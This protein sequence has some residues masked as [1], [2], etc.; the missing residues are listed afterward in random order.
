[1][2]LLDDDTLR[3]LAIGAGFLG[4]GGG[5]DTAY[6]LLAARQAVA[7]HGA[8]RLL[9][10][11]ELPDDGLLLPTG[12]MGAPTV[13]IEKIENGG[14][15]ERLRDAVQRE[16]GRPVVAVMASEIGGSNALTPIG[17]AA[18]MGL[19]V[20]DADGMGRAFPELQMVSMEVAG[21]SPCPAF[22]TDERGN[23]SVT[24]AVDGHWLER[25]HRRLTIELGG[26]AMTA[27]YVHTVAQ[28][29]TASIAGSVSL[30]L[31]IGR[32]I[33]EADDGPIEALLAAVH[34]VTL[35]RGK[36]VDVERRT[37]E[38]FAF[39]TVRLDGLGED[40]GRTLRIEVQNENL[41]AFE[42][43]RVL[44]AVPDLISIVDVESA[45]AIATERVRYGQR[46]AVVAC[47]C[48]PVWRTARGLA[49]TG[50]QAFGYD[51]EPVL[52][53]AAAP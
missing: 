5:G 34:G 40:R 21:I 51:L 17:W 19:P 33:D 15:G 9:G 31:A 22:I 53:P 52:L 42:G 50:P 48:A 43:E 7:D 30:A 27:E 20:V 49:L 45:H 1:M 36:I 3:L 44:A 10:L 2:T 46:V 23:L 32:A 4:T 26:S 39:G 25:L 12:G 37:R 6:G 35:L 8:P 28:A 41:L 14:E 47:P 18:R 29:R 24:R 38:G 16:F 13:G 11:D